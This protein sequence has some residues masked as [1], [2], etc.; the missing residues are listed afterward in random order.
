MLYSLTALGSEQSSCPDELGANQ[1]DLCLQDVKITVSTAIRSRLFYNLNSS[2]DFLIFKPLHVHWTYIAVGMKEPNA[3]IYSYT[4]PIQCWG[5]HNCNLCN[6]LKRICH[7]TLCFFC[8]HQQLTYA[9][10]DM[11]LLCHSD[12]H[13]QTL[14]ST[15]DMSEGEL[16]QLST[17]NNCVYFHN[18]SNSR[19]VGRFVRQE[20]TYM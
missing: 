9:T 10:E 14:K 5:L 1:S 19:T 3:H 6:S 2:N 12:E 15:V 8:H 20:C 11:I 16:K 18:V 4:G 7:R 17:Q 13:L